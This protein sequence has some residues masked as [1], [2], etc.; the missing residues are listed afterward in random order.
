MSPPTDNDT[1]RG[2]A[3]ADRVRARSEAARTRMRSRLEDLYDNWETPTSPQLIIKPAEPSGVPSKLPPGAAALVAL[4]PKRWR[5]VAV[6][7][8][9]LVTTA[10][11]VYQLWPR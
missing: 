11:S 9:A 10:F 7:A 2:L 4:L 1:K 3:Y 5:P 8:V 6:A